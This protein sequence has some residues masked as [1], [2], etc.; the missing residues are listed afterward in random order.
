MTTNKIIASFIVASLAMTT[1]STQAADSN[2]DDEWHFSFAPLFLWGMSMKGS[3][4]VGPTTAPLDL[5]FKDDVLESLEAVLT[6]HL[7]VQKNDLTVFAEYQYVDLDPDTELPNGAKVDVGFKNTM[8][9]FGAA[10]RVIETTNAEWEV[11]TGIRY[12]RQQLSVKDLP[13]PITVDVDED[14][15]DGFAGG[16]V[17]A[18]LS[19]NWQFIGRADIGTGGSKRVWNLVGM[20]DYRFKDWGSAFFGYKVMDY[21]Y[22]N[23]KSGVNHYAYDAKQQGPL[24]GLNFHW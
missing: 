9:E 4:E 8:A 24:A 12:T 15:Y 21:D 7:E 1:L 22:D 5:N 19:E 2:T 3:S 11:L 17:K 6:F 23:D 10:Y 18:K 20:V 14:W 16:R 13:L